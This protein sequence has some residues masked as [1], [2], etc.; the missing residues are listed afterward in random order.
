L[1]K[2]LNG[3]FESGTIE[4]SGEAGQSVNQS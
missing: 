3:L 4:P 2:G 1:K